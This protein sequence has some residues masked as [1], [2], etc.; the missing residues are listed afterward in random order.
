MVLPTDNTSQKSLPILT[1][2]FALTAC[3]IFLSSHVTELLQFDRTSIK[4]GELWR[5]ATG[6]F[7]HWNTEHLVWDVIPF[8]GLGA[9]CE[10]FNRKGF[11]ATLFAA[12]LLI[13]YAVWAFLPEMTTYRGI[14]GIDSALFLYA[15]TWI[16]IEN[17][18]I[19]QWK[20][21]TI[22]TLASI[23]FISKI[24][25]ETITK[26]TVFVQSTQLFSPVPIAHLIGGITGVLFASAT[27]YLANKR[28]TQ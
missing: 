19:R 28:G 8:V 11:A 22:A 20:S 24:T 16:F 6:H 27:Y 7:T 23:A 2:I 18:R 9:V 17:I 3:L 25:Y 1:S 14:S 10:K 15:A 26:S 21:V 12:C 4:T 13:S 5:L